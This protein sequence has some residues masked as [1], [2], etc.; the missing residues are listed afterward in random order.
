M[1][2]NEVGNFWTYEPIVSHPY[3]VS[4]YDTVTPLYTQNADGTITPADSTDP[5]TWLYKTWVKKDDQVIYA[6]TIKPVGGGSTPRM[7]CSM[8]HSPLGSR[9]AIW[10]S[11]NGTLSSYPATGLSFKKHIL[12]IFMSR[13]VSCHRPGETK[14]R[15]TMK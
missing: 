8:H 5:R 12:P 9:G 14:T 4:G 6:V 2:S 7:G 15:L 1:T 11:K 13:C 10:L 3:S